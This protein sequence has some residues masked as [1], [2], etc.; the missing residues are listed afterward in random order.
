ML[1]LDTSL[2]PSMQSLFC[3]SPIF[4]Q[5]QTYTFFTGRAYIWY[6]IVRLRTYP[7]PSFTDSRTP[8]PRLNFWKLN[9]VKLWIPTVSR[10]SKF[11]KV[12]VQN[13]R[14][15]LRSRKSTT[16]DFNFAGTLKVGLRCCSCLCY[17]NGPDSFYWG[18]IFIEKGTFTVRLFRWNLYGLRPGAKRRLRK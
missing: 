15:S 9:L 14:A 11:W 2:I 3:I 18:E 7:Q 16:F 10:Q 13:Y 1:S 8:S 6:W 17:W 12:H 5:R 4:V